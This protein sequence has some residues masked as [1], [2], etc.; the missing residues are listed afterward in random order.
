MQIIIMRHGDAVFQGG[1]RVLSE[2]GRKQ[3]RDTAARLHSYLK[4]TKIYTSPK[5]RARETADIVNEQFRADNLPFEVL[6]DLTPSGNAQAVV[7][8]VLEGAGKDDNILLVSH[9]PMVEYL[10]TGL[11]R[12]LPIPV[13]ET[14]SALVVSGSQDSW[15]EQAFFRPG[16]DPFIRQP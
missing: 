10:V 9:I 11:D 5:T 3:A 7:E 1:D 12:R 2:E 13:F 8:E 16:Y 4:L 14:A 15:A 6:K